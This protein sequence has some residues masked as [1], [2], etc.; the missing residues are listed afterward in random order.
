MKFTYILVLLAS[1]SAV[2]LHDDG[3]PAAAAPKAGAAEKKA[4]P[5]VPTTKSGITWNYQSTGDFPSVMKQR[6]KPPVVKKFHL[7]GDGKNATGGL[8]QPQK[9]LAP[10]KLPFDPMA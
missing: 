9:G 10:S 6:V 3:L 1:A 4:T 8:N 5:N 2:R 7:G